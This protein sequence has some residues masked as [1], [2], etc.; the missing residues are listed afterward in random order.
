MLGFG[1]RLVVWVSGCPFSCDS[2]IVEEL[3]DGELG[4][5]YSIDEFY[6]TIKTY[7]SKIDGI[8]FSGGEPLLQSNELIKLLNLLPY[9]LDKMLFTGFS[10]REWDKT[11]LKC[12]NIFDLVIE[13]RF[14]IEKMGD[15][16]WRGSSNQKILTPTKKYNSIIQDMYLSKSVGLDIKIDTE[17][18]LFYGIPTKKGEISKIKEFLNKNKISNLATY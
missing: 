2:C 15:F 13:G 11:Q 3:Q 10:R 9:D 5:D 12:F 7:I 16:L 8:T 4:A 17:E 6:N 18:I 1:N 14:E